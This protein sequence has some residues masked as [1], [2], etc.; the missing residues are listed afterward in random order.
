MVHL[1]L[2]ATTRFTGSST[3]GTEFQM[4]VDHF[5]SHEQHQLIV[6]CILVCVY[7]YV[8]IIPMP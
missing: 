4:V 5:I 3:K 2:R 1:P 6:F 7:H 8:Y